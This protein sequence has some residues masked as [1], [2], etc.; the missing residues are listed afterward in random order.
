[1]GHPRSLSAQVPAPADRRPCG[2]VGFWSRPALIERL[3]TENNGWGYK[4]IQGELLNL[5]QGDAPIPVGCLAGL[6][7]LRIRLVVDS[8]GDVTKANPAVIQAR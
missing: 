2:R 7:N 3:A 6:A 1:V 8:Y 5:G 4:W